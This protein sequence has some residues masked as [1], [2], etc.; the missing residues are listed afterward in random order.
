MICT[1]LEGIR[2]EN[3]PHALGNTENET[4]VLMILDV[5]RREDR[6]KDPTQRL[7]HTILLPTFRINTP[8]HN[9]FCSLARVDLAL[10]P[11]S[12]SNLFAAGSHVGPRLLL[13]MSLS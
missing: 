10:S 1:Q 9:I 13:S 4:N 12:R 7:P 3:G 8:I 11:E 5:Q 6:Q 2:H